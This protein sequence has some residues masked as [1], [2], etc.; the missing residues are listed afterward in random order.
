MDIALIVGVVLGLAAMIGSIALR[1]SLKDQRGALET[2]F[3]HRVL[4]LYL[5]V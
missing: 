3:Q 5:G 2:F 4:V 1:C